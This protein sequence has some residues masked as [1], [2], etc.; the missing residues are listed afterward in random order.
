MATVPQF[1]TGTLSRS[2]LN[3]F[4]TETTTNLTDTNIGA[5]ANIG[6]AKTA[7][8]TY[9]P[10]ASYAPTFATDAGT[11]TS[12]TTF[13]ARWMQLGKKVTVEVYATGTTAGAVVALAFSLPVTPLYP[14]A[15]YVATG[16]LAITNVGYISGIANYDSTP[17]KVYVRQYNTAVWTASAG[18][19]FSI[20]LTYEVA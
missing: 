10:W 6:I 2:S 14:T 18:V 11:W 12:I 1:P 7:L 20:Q 19:G 13:M 3:N 4:V 9:T 8:G 17:S 5:G 16:C 15:P